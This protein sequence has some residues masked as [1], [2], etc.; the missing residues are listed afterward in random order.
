MPYVPY[1]H[2]SERVFW[3]E[4]GLIAMPRLPIEVLRYS[5]SSKDHRNFAKNNANPTRSIPT[6]GQFQHHMV[7]YKQ[8]LLFLSVINRL[9]AQG[10][11]LSCFYIRNF[12]AASVKVTP[13]FIST[14]MFESAST[15]FRIRGR[16][17]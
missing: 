15:C 5:G 11:R 17:F 9:V 14:A 6:D 1:S 13:M 2:C 12:F 10:R 7:N 8:I 16:V 4:S 3:A